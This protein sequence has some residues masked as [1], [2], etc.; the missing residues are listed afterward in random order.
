MFMCVVVTILSVHLVM[1]WRLFGERSRRWEL[2]AL[3]DQLRMAGANSKRVRDSAAFETVD[4]AV[5]A[6]AANLKDF[7][8][9]TLIPA[10]ARKDRSGSEDRV[11]DEIENAPAE[12]AQ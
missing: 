4:I 5:T 11:R 6:L 8:L 3:R 10:L 7:S 9:W 12:C 2:F 1:M